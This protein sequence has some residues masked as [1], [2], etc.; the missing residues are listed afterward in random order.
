MQK[1]TASLLLHPLFIG[2]LAILLL[3]DGW[4]K[5]AF[6]GLVT[7]KLS[8]FAGLIVLP[9]FCRVL[10]PS[11]SKKH[12]L[13]AVALFFI[14]WKSPLSQ[15]LIE[16]ANRFS[17]WPLGRVV[18][19]SDLVA[20]CVLPLAARI[21]PKTIRLQASGYFFLRW[22]LGAVT[23][24]SL[25]ST[26]VYRNLFQAHPA[27]DDVYFGES[28]TIKRPVEHVLRN[29]EAKGIPYRLDSVMYYPITNQHHLFY[30]LQSPNDT[31]TAWHPVSMK[32]DSTLYVRREGSPFYFIPEFR[33]EDRI[34]RNIRF[35]VSENRKKTKTTVAVQ[36]F[37]ADGLRGY[38]DWDRKMK[39]E[40]T[41]IF[42]G[43]FSTK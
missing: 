14:W 34:I 10:F 18:D 16:I 21:Q 17:P 5:Y 4:G 26:S 9:V 28:I 33:T 35:T 22:A 43:L 12:L 13:F 20:L 15:P 6:P 8:D 32:Q 2:S 38:V 25:C 36:M 42:A 41:T 11:L 40:Y 27:M 31:S 29:L 1:T 39:K 3:N 24:F 19:F 37:Q 23:F 30:K 7:G